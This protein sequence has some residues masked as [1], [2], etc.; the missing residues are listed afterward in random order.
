MSQPV[1]DADIVELGV[2]AAA[3]AMRRG[4]LSAV[5]Y[6]S[7]LLDRCAD[8]KR[9]N[10]FITLDPDAVLVR[11]AAADKARKD[12]R[13]LGALHG[14]PIVIKDN[15]DVA[16][17]PTTAG[18][19]ALRNNQPRRDAAVVARLRAAG[20]F[21]LGKTNMHELAAGVT[22]NNAAFGTARNPYDQ[23]RVPG[24][25]SGGTAAAVAVRLAPADLGTDTGGSNRIPAAHCGV[26]G[27]RPTTGRWSQAGIAANAPL[28][29]TAGPLARTVADCALLDAVATGAGRPRGSVELPALRFG[30]HRE[31]LWTCLDEEVERVAESCLDRLRAA[32]V[33]VVEVDVPELQRLTDLAGF[34]LGVGAHATVLAEYLRESGSTLR[35]EDV[36]SAVS[37]PDVRAFLAEWLPRVTPADYAEARDVH[38]PKLQAT[39]RNIFEA[40][41]LDA[42]VFPTTPVPA[43]L[44]TECDK[45]EL[46]GA[47]VDTLTISIRNT[48]PGSVAGIPGLSLPAGTTRGGLP[49]GLALDAPADTDRR[50]FAIG[51]ALESVLPPPPTP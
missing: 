14:V 28:R 51:S 40:H 33:T 36:L 35:P 23:D 4:Q 24:G 26:V 41:A 19:P 3:A 9:L 5:R 7:V 10:A 47:L 31:L 22:T 30:I 50:L 32:G 29:D 8:F 45:V 11:A 13:P 42:L 16:G 39:Y 48:N 27:F 38:R 17:L 2:A 15:I 44:V 34:P 21:V 37:S 18:T 12:G 49:V 1:A 25:S 20:A 43:P 46:R 6:A